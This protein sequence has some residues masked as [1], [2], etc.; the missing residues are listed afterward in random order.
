MEG[1]DGGESLGIGLWIHKNS[2]P[3]GSGWEEDGDHESDELMKHNFIIHPFLHP[4]PSPSIPTL[5]QT[6]T[7]ISLSTFSSN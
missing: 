7:L 4:L 1:K 2:P 3:G 6:R 5:S